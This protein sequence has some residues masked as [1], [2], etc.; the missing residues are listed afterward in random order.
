[1]SDTHYILE[2][3]NWRRTRGSWLNLPGTDRLRS[4][5]DRAEA[6]A[7]CRE[8]EWEVR[9]TVNPFGCG[10]PFLHYQTAFD[11]AR[12]FDWCLDAG[13][14][15]PGVT[16]DSRVW[17]DWWATHHERMTDAQRA[18]V[19]EALDRV[20]FFRVV[21]SEADETCHL[22]AAQHFEEDPIGPGHYGRYRYVG[23]TPEFLA[24]RSKLADGLCHQLFVDAL[25]R[26]GSYLGTVHPP[27]SW[28]LPDDDP[29]AE[30]DRHRDR[31]ER[32]MWELH[33]VQFEHR[34]LVTFAD[35]PLR[36]GSD[37][38]VVLR[39][40]WRLDE[41]EIGFWRFCLTHSKSCGRPIAAFSTLAAADECMAKLEAEARRSPALFRFGRPHEWSYIDPAT[42]YG[43]LSAIAP[44]N[45]TSLWKDYQAPDHL[46]CRWWDD[47]A[48]TMTPEQIETVWAM[49]DKLKFYEVV[50]V[51]Y[52]E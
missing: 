22:V 30:E 39:R 27:I 4:F 43:M 12:L 52:R 17:A 40:H 45:I 21:E 8:R 48:P 47:A 46:W 33:Q 49:Y 26:L 29:F 42:I 34:P 6:D 9:R 25:A 7:L 11:A 5:S 14:D 20:R 44:V 51:E 24:Q 18:T 19:W 10:G 3:L 32:E 15:P 36:P 1:M 31:T 41:S 28:R 16:N 13:L 35:R 37:V 23:C 2:R 38:F 50:A